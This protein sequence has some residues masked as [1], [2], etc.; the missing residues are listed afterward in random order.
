MVKAKLQEIASGL[1][2]GTI[3]TGVTR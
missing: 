1:K 2:A 3:K